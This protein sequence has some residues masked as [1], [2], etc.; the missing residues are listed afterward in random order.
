MCDLILTQEVLKK[1]AE[2]YLDD[3]RYWSFNNVVAH[4]VA[5]FKELPYVDRA[6]YM[7]IAVNFYLTENVI[8]DENSGCFVAKT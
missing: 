5:S 8:V 4:K 7:K 2:L 1:A 3:V 6:Y